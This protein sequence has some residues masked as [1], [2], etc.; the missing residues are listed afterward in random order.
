[1]QT[2]SNNGIMLLTSSL[3]I[4]CYRAHPSIFLTR[5]ELKY[6]GGERASL[7]MLFYEEKLTSM[8]LFFTQI[9]TFI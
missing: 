8:T 9:W 3:A 2:Y 5:D 1:M 4:I 7:K 6:R